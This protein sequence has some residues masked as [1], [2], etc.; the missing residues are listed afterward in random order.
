M[1]VKRIIQTWSRIREGT[2]LTADKFTEDDLG[3]RAL[4]GGYSVQEI[5]LHIAHEEYG[6]IQYGLAKSIPGFPTPFPAEEYQD[7]ESLKELLSRVHQQTTVYLESLSDGDLEKEF[8]CGWGETRPL[9]DFILHVLEHEVHHR[10]EL[11][12]I[13]G[14]LGREGLDA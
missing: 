3:F 7:L 5:M 8:P 12:L 2:L 4:E 13:L 6:E 1:T 14:L 11:S 10:G 9:L